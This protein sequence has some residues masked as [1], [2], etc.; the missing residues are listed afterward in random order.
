[1]L[2]IKYLILTKEQHKVLSEIHEK[3]KEITELNQKLFELKEKENHSVAIIKELDE[4]VK[5]KKKQAD[6][7]GF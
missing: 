7:F 6:L 1:M 4:E 3:E 2:R 5:E